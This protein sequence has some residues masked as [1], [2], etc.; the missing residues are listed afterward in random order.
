MEIKT[1]IEKMEASSYNVGFVSADKV[2]GFILELKKA[3]PEKKEVEDGHCESCG[4]KIIEYKLTFTALHLNILQKIFKHCVATKQHEFSKKE[5]DLSH[6]DYGNFYVLQRFWLIYF[7]TDENGKR[8]KDG[9]WGVPMKRVS[10]FLR[11][12]LY[13]SEYFIRKRGENIASDSKIRVFDI[14]QGEKYFV[15]G[16]HKPLFVEYENIFNS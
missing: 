10:A 16:E 9:S 11:G 13:I 2:K 14:K 4:Q 8:I 15:P 5:I 7:K 12:D 1:I 6:T 3:I